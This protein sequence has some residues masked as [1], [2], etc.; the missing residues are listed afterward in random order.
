MLK[1]DPLI[2]DLLEWLAIKPRPYSEVMNAW[3]TS[4]PR[5]TIWEDASDSGFVV[6]RRTTDQEPLVDLTPEGR[7]LLEANARRLGS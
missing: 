7:G 5:L 4:C 6:V 1:V 2:L 3:R